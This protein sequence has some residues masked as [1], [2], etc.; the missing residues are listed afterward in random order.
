MGAR[1]NSLQNAIFVVKYGFGLGAC[2][3]GLALFNRQHAYITGLVSLIF[4]ALGAFFLSAVRIELEG[5]T[6][7]YRRWTRWHSLPYSQI[8]DCGESWV[9]GYIRPRR[10]AFPWGKIYFLRPNASDSLFGLDKETISI[11]RSKAN[12]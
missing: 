2:G 3:F 10:F 12:I 4:L 9:Y 8:Q 7:K 11:I 5:E 1:E 6:V